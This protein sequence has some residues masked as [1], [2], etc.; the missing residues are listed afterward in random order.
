MI[1]C[2]KPDC[3]GKIEMS[4]KVYFDVDGEIR[5]GSAVIEEIT[6]SHLNDVVGGMQLNLEGELFVGCDECGAEVDPVFALGIEV[7]T[8]SERLRRES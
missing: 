2:P 8:Q 3:E 7:D 1:P 6:Y 4:S 5:E